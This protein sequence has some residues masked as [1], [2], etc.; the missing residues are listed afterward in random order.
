[1]DNDTFKVLK[2]KA[3]GNDYIILCH[4]P[5]NPVTPWATWRTDKVDG[6]GN[7][8]WGHYFYDDQESDAHRDF[9]DR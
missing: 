8:F 3:V 4:L 9:D 1:M 6:S 7:R 5:N 2:A